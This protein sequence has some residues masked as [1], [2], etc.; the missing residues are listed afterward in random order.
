MFLTRFIISNVFSVF[1]IG[2]I[3]LLKRVLKNK[4]SLKF[5]YHIWFVLLLS[6]M[7]AFL[8]TTFFK[9]IELGNNAGNHSSCEPYRGRYTYASRYAK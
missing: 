3:L 4:V 1:L 6:F 2:A 5:H 8:P 9:S 7:V